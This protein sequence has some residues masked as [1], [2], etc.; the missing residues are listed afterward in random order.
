MMPDEIQALLEEWQHIRE[1]RMFSEA[2]EMKAMM[3]KHRIL[4]ENTR[5]GPAWRT[6]FP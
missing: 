4:F 5:L 3:S 6:M 2:D 1:A